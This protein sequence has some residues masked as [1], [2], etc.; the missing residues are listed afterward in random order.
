MT[1]T[2]FALPQEMLEALHQGAR[3]EGLSS[4]EVCRRLIVAWIE[5]GLTKE[6]P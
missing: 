1:H 6:K 3:R 4:A 2:L 5:R